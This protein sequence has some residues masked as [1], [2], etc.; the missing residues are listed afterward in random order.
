MHPSFFFVCKLNHT[1][2]Q[3]LINILQ[4]SFNMFVSMIQNN[5]YRK[6][7]WSHYKGKHIIPIKRKH[8]VL[9]Y[10]GKHVRLTIFSYSKSEIHTCQHFPIT[11]YTL[12]TYLN[13]LKTKQVPKTLY[14]T[15]TITCVLYN[16]F[17]PC[18]LSS[19][20]QS[21]R[22]FWWKFRKKKVTNKQ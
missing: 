8:V 17:K 19:L 13:Q 7:C 1:N 2:L 16:H 14:P 21:K 15:V 4:D 3:N 18:K 22:L 6:A 11:L 10:K 12:T 5:V 9:H 20:W